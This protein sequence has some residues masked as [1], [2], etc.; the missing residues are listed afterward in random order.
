MPIAL[1][2]LEQPLRIELLLVGLGSG[3]GGASS[4][5]AAVSLLCASTCFWSACH[6]RISRSAIRR[7][8]AADE[9]RGLTEEPA[10]EERPPP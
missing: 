10:R 6:S 8:L 3:A 5:F 9:R 7:P 4:R 1:L 2:A